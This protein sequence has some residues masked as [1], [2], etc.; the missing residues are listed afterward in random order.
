MYIFRT[1]VLFLRLL[2]NYGKDLHT[3]C[4]STRLSQGIK[5]TTCKIIISSV[6][7]N[8]APCRRTRKRRA[9]RAKFITYS[10]PCLPNCSRDLWV[11]KQLWRT[12]TKLRRSREL[13]LMCILWFLVDQVIIT[14]REYWRKPI[15]KKH[16]QNFS[17][18][19]LGFAFVWLAPKYVPNHF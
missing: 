14:R 11:L 5:I 15:K 4:I 3:F 9:K 6:V 17:A 18:K 8:A 16:S 7:Q 2:S 1:F 19:I 13:L 12:K 10:L